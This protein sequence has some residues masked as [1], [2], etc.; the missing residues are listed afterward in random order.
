MRIQGQN[1]G[2]ISPCRTR[3]N[4]TS[5]RGANVEAAQSPTQQRPQAA[6]APWHTVV[7]LLSLG[8]L[9]FRA[10]L[11]R[12]PVTPAETGAAAGQNSLVVKYLLIILSEIGM[13]AWVWAGVRWKGGRFR[14]LIG[15]RW[16][17]RRIIVSDIGIALAYWV[18]WEITA[19]LAHVA[20]D[21]AHAATAPYHVPVGFAEIS[22][23]IVV[24]T[25][26][27]FC[28]ELTYRGYFQQQFHALTGNLPAAIILQG[29]VF[30]FGHS[31]Q[32]WGQVVIIT[33]LGILDGVFVWWRG[34]LRA[35]MISHA[36]ADLYEG[37]LQFLL[38]HRH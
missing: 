25:L 7:L 14:D 29:L 21:P 30:G 6:A 34:N 4:A 9:G 2:W 22:L 33:V 28:E 37:Y 26:A 8:Y 24:S 18:V 15:G 32:G 20:V 23:W 10:M 1:L 36:W 19:M 3:A 31:Y 27:G 13:A 17:N 5:N 38:F 35:G 11:S 12:H 16:N